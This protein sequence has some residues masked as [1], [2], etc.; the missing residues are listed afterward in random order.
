MGRAITLK[1]YQLPRLQL[2]S[3]AQLSERPRGSRRQMLLI[4][5]LDLALLPQHFQRVLKA[6]YVG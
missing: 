6:K 4:F 3:L 2:E 5:T 1:P